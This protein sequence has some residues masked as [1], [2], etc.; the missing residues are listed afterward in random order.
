[1]ELERNIPILSN[2]INLIEREAKKFESNS[3][4]VEFLISRELLEKSVIIH[5]N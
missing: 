5:G 4:E 3:G 2:F 1:M